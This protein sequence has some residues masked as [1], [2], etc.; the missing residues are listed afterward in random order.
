MQSVPASQNPLMLMSPRFAVGVGGSTSGGVCVGDA[1]VPGVVGFGVGEFDW[2]FC[3]IGLILGSSR[4]ADGLSAFAQESANSCLI[5]SCALMVR[6]PN[7]Q[8]RKWSTVASFPQPSHLRGRDS[9][10]M[11]YLRL[12][13]SRHSSRPRHVPLIL[14]G[15]AESQAPDFFPL[16]MVR[17][18]DDGM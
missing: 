8:I 1:G 17:S 15:I 11:P 3:E 13:M 2:L 6:P 9:G 12:A 4:T 16:L 10:R 14:L 7:G 5:S 18:R